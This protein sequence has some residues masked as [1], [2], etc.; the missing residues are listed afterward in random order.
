MDDAYQSIEAGLKYFAKMLNESNGD[1]EEALRRYNG[2]GDPNYVSNVLR[3]N[4]SPV[5]VS[6]NSSI[7]DTASAHIGEDVNG[8]LDYGAGAENLGL[9][10]AAFVSTVLAE[11]G[12][13][14]LNSVNVDTLKEQ[15]E[16]QGLYHSAESGYQPKKGDVIIWGHHTG[17]SDGQG[18]YIARN[19]TE[20][21][22]LGNEL[23]YR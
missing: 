17:F 11:A 4:Y 18:N 21:V 7:W 6:G 12:I 10:C 22:H 1:I 20:G 14:G 23:E 2:G 15:A 13:E 8:L 16:A 5:G 19:S 9:Q 3:H